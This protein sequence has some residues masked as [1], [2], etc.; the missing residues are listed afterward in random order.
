[1]R[2]VLVVNALIFAVLAAAV[3]LAYYGFSA[4]S[5]EAG[6]EREME[7]LREL[8]EEKVFNIENLVVGDERTIRRVDPSTG[9]VTTIVGQAAQIGLR[10]GPLPGSFHTANS[11]ALLPNGDLVVVDSGENVVLLVRTPP[12]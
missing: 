10:T 11:L 9:A 6:R 1:M 7:P 5:F 3:A 8:A 2:R 12:P 4:S